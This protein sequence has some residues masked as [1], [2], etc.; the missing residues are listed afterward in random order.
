MITSIIKKLRQ[1]GK[2]KYPFG[3][4]YLR[5][6]KKARGEIFTTGEKVKVRAYKAVSFRASK[7]LKRRVKKLR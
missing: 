1:D 2:A 6:R 3:T 5:K 7:E 4:F